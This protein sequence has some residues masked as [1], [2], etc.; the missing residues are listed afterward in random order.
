MKTV[1]FSLI[2]IFFFYTAQAQQIRENDIVFSKHIVRSV[3]LTQK[4]NQKWFGEDENQLRTI[5]LNAYQ[6]GT[7]Q[8]W[9]SENFRDK[10]LYTSFLE[11]I[12]FK[13]SGA[14]GLSEIQNYTWNDFEIMEVGEE[15]LFD[16]N[17]SEFLF[18][19]TSVTF[20]IPA[21][22]SY[23]GLIERMVSFRFDDVL[24]V[25]KQ[26][27]NLKGLNPL[28]NNKPIEY[29][30]VFTLRTYKNTIVKIGGPNEPYFDQ[31]SSDPSLAYLIGKSEE[32]KL[33]ELVY[34]FYTPR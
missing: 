21:Y 13:T 19:T 2:A 22:K 5:L 31:I 30:T 8:G 32:D 27:K 16:K 17:R 15:F 24:A 33:K 14:D 26:T 28:Q 20:F 12:S 25:V 23:R 7:L 9:E 6:S 3:N 34:K 1:F 4:D 11:K 29:S 18:K 10:L